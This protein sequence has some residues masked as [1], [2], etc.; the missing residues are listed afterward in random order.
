[1]HPKIA[2]IGST[3]IRTSPEF[4]APIRDS[5]K[6]EEAAYEIGREL[7][8]RGCPII[9]HS[10]QDDFVERHV[11]RGYVA[12]G[13]AKP[14]SIHAWGRYSHKDGHFPEVADHR[15][16]FDLQ[17]DAAMDWEV[18]FYRSI[19][20]ADGV[21]LL[22]GGRSTYIAGLISLSRR[23]PLVAVAYFGGGGEK[24]WAYAKREPNH[25]TPAELAAMAESWHSGSA[26]EIAGS[27]IDQHT[28]R[29]SAHGLAERKRKHADRRTS[30]SLIIAFGLLLLALGTIPL[31]YS[32]MPG[33]GPGLAALF[34][35]PLFAAT[36]GAIVRNAADQADDWIRTTVLG[37]TAGAIAFMLFVAAQL[38]TTPDLLEGAGARRLLFFVIPV[39][40][41][42]GLTFDA[43]YSKL[44]SQDVTNTSTLD[45]TR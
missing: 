28:R 32:W 13:Q 3:G 14:K 37:A 31:S 11:V 41:T 19:L 25:A 26:A 23:I 2:I 38:A 16:L 18:S 8:V 43:V 34:M 30:Q 21:L 33:S 10:S 27:L 7:A 9:V 6:A 5:E 35:A 45:S 20:I 39:A 29:L 1:M 24:I 22:G 12:S 42:A 17:P 36:C 15:E 40:F 4:A 44:R